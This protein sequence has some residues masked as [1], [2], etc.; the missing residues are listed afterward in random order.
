[1]VSCEF[2]EIIIVFFLQATACVTVKQ[3]K[4]K[5]KRSCVYKSK[6]VGRKNFDVSSEAAI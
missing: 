2:C 1:M 6:Y 5:L 3:R 4:T